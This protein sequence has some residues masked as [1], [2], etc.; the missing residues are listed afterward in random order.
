MENPVAS[1]LIDLPLNPFKGIESD[2][3]G[4][5]ENLEHELENNSPK[6]DYQDGKKTM[7]IY[8]MN[9]KLEEEQKY[10]WLNAPLIGDRNVPTPIRFHPEV[11]SENERA[12]LLLL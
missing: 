2:Q 1:T 9:S 7:N 4:D 11:D 8:S 5:I 10:P 3:V 12:P 6:S